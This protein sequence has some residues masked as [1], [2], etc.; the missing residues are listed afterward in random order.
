[1]MRLRRLLASLREWWTDTESGRHCQVPGCERKDIP[2]DLL[3]C[4]T[5]LY[6]TP[7]PVR[8]EWHHLRNSPS[9]NAER[10][11]FWLLVQSTWRQ[12][13]WS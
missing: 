11:A 2:W 12:S 13:Q 9:S 6:R 8:A 4:W 1:M 7:R 5:H 10:H 3:A